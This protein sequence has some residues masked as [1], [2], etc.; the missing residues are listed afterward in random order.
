MRQSLYSVSP[1]FLV[2]VQFHWNAICDKSL[3]CGYI[4]LPSHL[5]SC[6][7]SELFYCVVDYTV[8]SCV[9]A[10]TQSRGR[11]EE[12][13]CKPISRS[14]GQALSIPNA[15]YITRRTCGSHDGPAR[16]SQRDLR[17]AGRKSID[18]SAELGYRGA[19]YGSARPARLNAK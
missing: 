2:L 1:A 4:V 18:N 5:N 11:R 13:S 7:T 16:S 14:H 17:F 8:H 9:I 3:E 10:P 19:K 12:A 6:K 15:I